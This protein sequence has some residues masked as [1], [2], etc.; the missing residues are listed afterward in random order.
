M[1][2]TTHTQAEIGFSDIRS[3]LHL[4]AKALITENT[5]K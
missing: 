2:A 4:Q 3:S 1:Q 5:P